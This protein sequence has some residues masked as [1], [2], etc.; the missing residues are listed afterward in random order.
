MRPSA[1]NAG[2]T[3]WPRCACCGSAINGLKLAVATSYR[4]RSHFGCSS[5]G[6]LSSSGARSAKTSVS[7][8][9]D[10]TRSFTSYN[11]SS[12]NN[13]LVKSRSGESANAFCFSNRR[14][15]GLKA[16]GS[17]NAG[18]KGSS[19]LI[20]SG[21]STNAS[22]IS[23]TTGSTG[24]CCTLMSALQPTKYRQTEKTH[25]LVITV[26]FHTSLLLLRWQDGATY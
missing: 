23:C 9:G 18:W 16:L 22:A 14:A 15:P 25:T 1:K 26:I 4:H 20:S 12:G 19:S 24:S 8:S 11:A 17:N 3:S 6:T 7:P 5:S 13:A 2:L 21:R 10:A